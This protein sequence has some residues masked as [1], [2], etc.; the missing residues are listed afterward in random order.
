MIPVQ[1]ITHTTD[2]YD[3]EQGATEALR[4]GCR[5]IQLRIKG[6]SDEEMRPIAQK[7][8]AACREHEAMFIID[9]RVH[10]AKSIGAD[11]VHLGRTDMPIPEAR[12][13]LGEE[14]IIGGTANT[15]DDIRRLRREGADY[16]GC[17]PFR[18][19]QTKENLAPTLGLEGYRTL[20]EAMR[21]E[22]IRLPLCAIGGIELED[23]SAIMDTGVNGIAVSGAILRAEDPAGM[24]RRF[25]AGS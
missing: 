7:L 13:I 12:A 19:T 23:V 8:L 17:G 20:V 6:A 14:M 18:F 24:M 15:I 10:L 22:G 11:G 16:I 21:S 9:D 3:Y 2:R 5:W 4:G 1:F 25:I